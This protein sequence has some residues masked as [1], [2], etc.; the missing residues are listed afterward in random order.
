MMAMLDRDVSFRPVIASIDL[1]LYD[2]KAFGMVSKSGL[3]AD[4]HQRFVSTSLGRVN[5]DKFDFFMSVL[6]FVRVPENEHRSHGTLRFNN[7]G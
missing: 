3:I 7:S 4:T 1:V 6:E 5:A 2:L